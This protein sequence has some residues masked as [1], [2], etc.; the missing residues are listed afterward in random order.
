MPIFQYVKF[1]NPFWFSHVVR[2]YSLQ[3]RG[4]PTLEAR[5]TWQ[6]RD[7]WTVA[8]IAV[9]LALAGVGFLWKKPGVTL[10]LLMLLGSLAQQMGST[11]GNAI[12]VA[13]PTR[14]VIAH[15]F[16]LSPFVAFVLQKVVVRRWWGVKV[17]VGA[18]GAC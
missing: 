5:L 4:M 2:T 9:P 16:F 3:L 11:L 15:A 13:A 7:I 8:G 12:S 14:G 10:C 18:L 6:I 17:A 1:G